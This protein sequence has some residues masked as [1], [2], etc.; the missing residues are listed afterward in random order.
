MATPGNAEIISSVL[1]RVTAGYVF[2][3]RA[4][5]VDRALRARL[6]AGEYDALSGAALCEAVTGH[7]QEACPD[8]H[9]R[10]LWQDEPRTGTSGCCGRTSPGRSP[11]PRTRARAGRRS[12]P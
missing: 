3:R 7:L 2:P 1:D 11:H 6:A 5:E 8:R 12:S 10:L 9:L 4:A